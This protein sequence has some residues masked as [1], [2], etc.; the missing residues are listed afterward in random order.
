MSITVFEAIEN[1]KINIESSIK[2]YGYNPMLAVAV[3]QLK[4]V[5]SAL[6]SGTDVDSEMIILEGEQ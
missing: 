4:N 2:V 6:E 3:D 1:A 5:I